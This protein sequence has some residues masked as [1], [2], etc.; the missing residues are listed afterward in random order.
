MSKG[1]VHIDYIIAIGIIIVI[2]VLT[3]LF[4]TDFL[5]PSQEIAQIESV[6]TNAFSLLTLVDFPSSPTVWNDTQLPERIGLKTKSYKFFIKINNSQNF[7]INQSQ[8]PVNLTNELVNFSF[9]DIG[10][11]GIDINSVSVM[12]DN[13]TFVPYE[14][15]GSEIRFS[16]P[17]NTSQARWYT[18]YFDDDSNFTSQSIPIAATNNITETVFP[19]ERIDTVQYRQ[20]RQLNISNYS[21]TRN[22]FLHDFHLKLTD[23]STSEIQL[24]YG[25][26]IPRRGDVVALQRYVIYQNSTAHVNEGRLVVQ[27]W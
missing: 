23:L 15:S 4:A 11:G 1:F 27:T 10:F 18:I 21:L 25:A 3:L 22:I 13:N 16:V 7:Y 20:L 26:E 24:D 2:F 8:S 5:A 14:I 6:T 12:D 19:A 9:S 17:I